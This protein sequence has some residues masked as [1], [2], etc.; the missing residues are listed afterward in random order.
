MTRE[1]KRAVLLADYKQAL[2]LY[3]RLKERMIREYPQLDA[4]TVQ[5]LRVQIVSAHKDLKKLERRVIGAHRVKPGA[6]PQLGMGF[7]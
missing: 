4:I 6:S 5:N 1:Q 2:G 7:E 3:T